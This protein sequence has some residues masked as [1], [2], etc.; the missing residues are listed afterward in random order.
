M[1]TQ[2]NTFFEEFIK[3]FYL[4]LKQVQIYSVHHPN[5]QQSIKKAFDQLQMAMVEKQ[6]V[7]ISILEGTLLIDDL[8]LDKTNSIF[9]KVMQ[10]LQEKGLESAT[11]FQRVTSEEFRD[12]VN[13]IAASPDNL[14][15]EGGI[16]SALKKMNIQNFKVNVVKYGKL[17]PEKDRLEDMI[18]SNYFKGKITLSE[19]EEGKFAAELAENPERISALL[20][21]TL[22]NMDVAADT[23]KVAGQ[24]QATKDVIDKV[25]KTVLP[26]R[27]GDWKKLKRGLAQVILGLNP[28]LQQRLLQSKEGRGS[29]QDGLSVLTGEL[30][31][32]SI[33]EF[34]AKEYAQ[35]R[36]TLDEV[37]EA[38]NF[39]IPQAR[40]NKELALTIEKK[41]IAGGMSQK[42]AKEVLRYALWKELSLEDKARRVLQ[43]TILGKYEIKRVGE[44]FQELLL[45]GQIRDA[46]A[47]LNKFFQAVKHP[48]LEVRTEV[49]DQVPTI[50]RILDETSKEKKIFRQAYQFLLGATEQEKDSGVLMRLAGSLST[51]ANR[52]IGKGNYV[53][54][55]EIIKGLGNSQRIQY[56]A[57]FQ[58]EKHNIFQTDI[59]LKLLAALSEKKG[60]ERETI[61][62]AVVQLGDLAIEPLL[63]ALAQ[64]KSMQIRAKLIKTIASLGE[65][66]IDYLIPRL[67]DGRWFVVR[68]VSTILG[69][70][71]SKKTVEPLI[72]AAQHPDPRVRKEALIA[73]SKIPTE[74]SS[75]CILNALEDFDNGILALASD[76]AAKLG[77][78]EALPLL[79]KIVK[80]T[81]RFQTIDVETRRKAITAFGRLAPERAFTELAGIFEKKGL[82][83]GDEPTEIKVSSVLA[84][85]FS[86]NKKA[87]ELLERLSKKDPKPEVKEA[88]KK[89]LAIIK[90]RIT[91]VS[92]E[93]TPV[94]KDHVF[95]E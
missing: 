72:N 6:E 81:E 62:Q 53:D 95:Y 5:S 54:G 60:E 77:I 59:I 24:V 79:L 18:I 42:S 71:K 8:P 82:F 51:V 65:S 68:N 4:A 58:G 49:A 25:T 70:I 83:G 40:D 84:L 16:E 26:G 76:L 41:L 15:K 80:K 87:M 29:Q 43:S 46:Q 1:T 50:L 34:I 91:K 7:T 23:D 32:D 74:K 13:L 38:I 45:A 67:N 44:V 2:D 92:A 78:K 10:E 94:F 88:A 31:P 73:L 12:F 64:E 11:I 37:K 47:V 61:F 14:K 22:E 52:L 30:T 86:D 35:N 93:K 57:R 33:A 89:A 56:D 39:L 85:G 75:Q 3:Q 69:D 9:T 21:S 63:E 48:S 28:L 55:I 20:S 36:K 17:S 90:N 27:E 66:A 19:E